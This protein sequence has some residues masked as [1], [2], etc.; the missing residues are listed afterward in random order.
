MSIDQYMEYSLWSRAI[1]TVGGTHPLHLFFHHLISY[2]FLDVATSW[3][4]TKNC[5]CAHTSS[6]LRQ[7]G[8]FACWFAKKKEIIAK[9]WAPLFSSTCKGGFPSS[10]MIE[11]IIMVPSGVGRHDNYHRYNI[12]FYRRQS[13]RN[14]SR[15]MTCLGDG[16]TWENHHDG[17]S[18]TFMMVD[19]S[20]TFV[21]DSS[22]VLH[23]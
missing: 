16:R 11:Y 9:K 5:I 17:S 15:M 10:W 21:D 18:A 4:C 7:Q 20:W 22:A 13:R 1:T 3:Y 23:E 12:S 19:L 6:I 2:N 8:V 14:L